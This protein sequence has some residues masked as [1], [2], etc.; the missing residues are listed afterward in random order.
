MS[1]HINSTLG[2]ACGKCVIWEMKS[3]RKR[4]ISCDWGAKSKCCWAPR[5]WKMD[6]ICWNSDTILFYYD[7][8]CTVTQCSWWGLHTQPCGFPLVCTTA[9]CMPCFLVLSSWGVWTITSLSSLLCVCAA[10]VVRY[11]IDPLSRRQCLLNTGLSG[12]RLGGIGW[13]VCVVLMELMFCYPSV[14]TD[15][16]MMWQCVV[17]VFVLRCTWPCCSLCLYCS[18]VLFCFTPYTICFLFLFYV[19]LSLF[20]RHGNSTHPFMYPPSSF[21]R[22]L[23]I[24]CLFFVCMLPRHFQPALV[25]MDA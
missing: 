4:V 20:P 2:K 1:S 11:C 12:D 23:V 17:C 5:P 10:G 8:L 18:S 13:P 6:L 21:L 16:C 9:Y 3:S 25:C 24:W 19:L 22:H 15:W 14:P 7:L